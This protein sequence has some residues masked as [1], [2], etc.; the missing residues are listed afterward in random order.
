M[1]K[2]IQLGSPTEPTT[3]E[4]ARL[5]L[6]QHIQRGIVL[7]TQLHH[8][9]SKEDLNSKEWTANQ[10]ATNELLRIFSSMQ[11]KTVT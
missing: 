8:A 6:Q 11:G 5:D 4:S 7:A 10:A 1:S 2:P 9:A 3:T